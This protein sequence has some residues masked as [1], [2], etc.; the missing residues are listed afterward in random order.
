MFFMEIFETY[1][2]EVH[3]LPIATLYIKIK[4]HD[5]NTLQHHHT[6]RRTQLLQTY[7]SLMKCW[8]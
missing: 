1:Y 5:Q 2:I 7:S 8:I 3:L 6:V 4:L